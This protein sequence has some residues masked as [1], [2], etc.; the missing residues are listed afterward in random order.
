[1]NTLRWSEMFSTW[2]GGR[3]SARW[4]KVRPQPTLRVELMKWRKTLY[5]DISL[6]FFSDLQ[7]LIFDGGPRHFVSCCDFALI[8]FSIEFLLGRQQ[9]VCA[10]SMATCVFHL[11]ESTAIFTFFSVFFT[12]CGVWFRLNFQLFFCLTHSQ[13]PI[14]ESKGPRILGLLLKDSQ[15]LYLQ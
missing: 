6:F 12:G 5:D 8:F 14:S 7:H 15:Q 10:A 3:E 11:T 13:D 4:W 2:W 1:M 9:N